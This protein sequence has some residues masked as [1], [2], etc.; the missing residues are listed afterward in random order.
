MFQWISTLN[1][2]KYFQL[3]KFILNKK[4]ELKKLFQNGRHNT[5]QN[6]IQ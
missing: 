4:T 5:Q 1:D 2:V 6:N 3:N